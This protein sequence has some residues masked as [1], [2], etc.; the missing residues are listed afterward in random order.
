MNSDNGASGASRATR[1]DGRD[2]AVLLVLVRQVGALR[3]AVH[4]RA[5]EPGA[6]MAPVAI[7]VERTAQ[8]MRARRGDDVPRSQQ[9]RP[10]SQDP[11]VPGRRPWLHE[12]HG[13]S[14]PGS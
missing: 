7:D 14:G 5:L 2:V 3:L 9:L 6:E 12:Q 11:P 8:L 13:R 1:P 4:G 10:G